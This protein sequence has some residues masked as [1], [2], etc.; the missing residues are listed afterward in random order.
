MHGDEALPDFLSFSLAG[1]VLPSLVEFVFND[2]NVVIK[3]SSLLEEIFDDDE[4]VRAKDGRGLR[5]GVC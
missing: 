1:G 5:L 4:L 2:R 3:G